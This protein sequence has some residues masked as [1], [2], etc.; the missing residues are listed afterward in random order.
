[1]PPPDNGGMQLATDWRGF[2]IPMVDTH[3][4]VRADAEIALREIERVR[5][6]L[7]AVQ[8]RVIAVIDA[9]GK[10]AAAFI[11]RTTGVS[12]KAAREQARVAKV[13]ERLEGAGEA[14]ARGRVSSEHL[15]SLAPVAD[16][17]EAAS[18]IDIASAQTPE[19][20][21]KTV[22]RYQQVKNPKTFRERQREA[23]SVSFFSADN[24]CIG[25]RAILPPIEGE[26][27]QDRL[28]QIADA[29]WRAEHPERAEN[30]GGHD[31]EPLHRRLADALMELIRGR[32]GDGFGKPTIVVTVDAK[33]LEANIVGVGPVPL[34][35][36]VT[37]VDRSDLYACIRSTSG[38]I[39]KF[40]RNRRLASALQQ[41]AL[42]VRD[43]KCV[44]EG[45]DAHWNRTQAHHANDFEF[46][47][48]TNLDELALLCKP[49]HSHLHQNRL[50]ITFN[51]Q[52]W[53]VEPD[54]RFNDSLRETE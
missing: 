4:W 53:R 24:G 39:L 16:D 13:V 54:P 34:G 15:R 50:R 27:L 22:T 41:L 14:L 45:C 42:V 18:L 2:T 20:F 44:Y 33:T 36:V 51:K 3:G 32:A 38:G 25:M 21:R 31:G 30:L 1:M 52:R 28:S 19:E 40:G 6:A 23:R 26:E 35:D 8:A 17:P 5:R 9:S 49:H 29:A 47:G 43:G 46:G 7:D 11:A 37:M 48:L 12:T 10:D